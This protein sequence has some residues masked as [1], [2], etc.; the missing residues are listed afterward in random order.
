MDDLTPFHDHLHACSH[1]RD[2]PLSL[3][4]VGSALFKANCCPKLQIGLLA[5]AIVSDGKDP[6]TVLIDRLNELRAARKS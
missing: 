3:C 6:V 5:D 4:P 2:N 1:C